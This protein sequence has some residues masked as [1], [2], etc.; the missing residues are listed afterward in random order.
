LDIV[1]FEVF[2]FHNRGVII[3]DWE[4]DFQSIF[5]C[6]LYECASENWMYNWH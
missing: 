1:V 3:I 4:L 6:A 5:C 2:L